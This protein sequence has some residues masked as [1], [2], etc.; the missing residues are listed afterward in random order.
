MKLNAA[1]L[2]ILCASCVSN[3]DTEAH[4]L[5]LWNFSYQPDTSDE[6]KVYDR[7]DQ[8][9]SGDCEDFAL[10]LQKQI[11]GEVWYV[12]L[13]DGTAHAALVKNDTVYDNISRRPVMIGD[14]RGQFISVISSQ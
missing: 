4:R 11:G 1:V 10:T 3:P 12:L 9:F 8:P 14:Y 7:I 6:W 13:L 2:A 5:A